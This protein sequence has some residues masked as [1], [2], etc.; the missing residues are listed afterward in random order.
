MP[1]YEFQCKKCGKAFEVIFKTAAETLKVCCPACKS[2][3]VQKFLS[4]LSPNPEKPKNI[5]VS[6]RAHACGHG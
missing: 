1:I 2:K 3:N 5:S 6:P 4:V